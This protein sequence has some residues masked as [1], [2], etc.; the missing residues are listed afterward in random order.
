MFEKCG[1]CR[2][3]QLWKHLEKRGVGVRNRDFTEQPPGEIRGDCRRHAPIQISDQDGSGGG[4]PDTAIDDGCGDYAR[5]PR[6]PE[7]EWKGK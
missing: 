4:W 7:Y 5:T 1:T 6:S 2:F 3:W